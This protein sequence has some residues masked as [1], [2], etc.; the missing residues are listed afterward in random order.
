MARVSFSV[1]IFLALFDSSSQQA[2]P[3]QV[4][5]SKMNYGPDG[6]WHA[7]TVELGSPGQAI[8]LLP[9]GTFRS[10]IVTNYACCG[11]ANMFYPDQSSSLKEG[12]M[13]ILLGRISYDGSTPIGSGWT[14]G[15]L[16]YASTNA[17]AVTDTLVLSNGPS[18]SNATV[19]D[20]D[21]Y[22]WSNVQVVR[23][24]GFLYPLQI[25]QLALGNAG[26]NQT[27]TRPG[28]PSIN[29]SLVPNDL[30]DQ[31][32][33]DSS[34]F[35]LHYGSAPLGLDLSLWFGGY[36]QLR[37]LAPVSAQEYADAGSFFIDLYDIGIGVAEGRSP[38]TNAPSQG[39]LAS[40]NDTLSHNGSIQVL[41]NPVAPYLNLPKST[42]DAIAKNLPV[43]YNTKY[44]FYL[45]NTNDPQ[46]IN[47]VTSPA[48]LNFSFAL[49]GGLS[50][51]A[52]K[53]P[54]QLLNLTL[55]S[56]LTPEP[57]QYFPC[58][59]PRDPNTQ[60]YSLGRA[61]LQAAF[62]G[63]NWDEG[64]HWYLAQAPGP[65]VASNPD[66]QP[67]QGLSGFEPSPGDSDSWANTWNK[68]WKVTPDEASP[69]P[70]PPPAPSKG[71][72]S[73]GAIAGIAT[74][75]VSGVAAVLAT[76]WLLYRRRQQATKA[77]ATA[78][79]HK[80]GQ[81]QP[82]VDQPPELPN[83]GYAP[84]ELGHEGAALGPSELSGRER[85]EMEHQSE[86]VGSRAGA[87]S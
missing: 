36:D 16:M 86:L 34:S 80:V 69:T 72:I 22:M 14:N 51:F 82:F 68:T 73:G 5:Q 32:I 13:D 50:N 29:A 58:Q 42:C 85:Y 30:K 66:Y 75:A 55:E 84:S 62:L 53:V 52:I 6:P 33:I 12:D 49:N 77:E 74:G 81:S 2:Y 61:F 3:L 35:G 79:V 21:I 43:T 26:S 48:Y 65:G 20:F 47:I 38:F 40:G 8:D 64:H 76:A 46:Y 67:I 87:A 28:S 1:I 41:I 19:N 78:Y 39:L 11:S 44:G 57:I 17:S 63:V 31:N 71:G 60:I 54:F 10:Q 70:I 83:S 7:V 24:D 18:T 56:P 37:A 9:G 25:G 59:P 4:R 15:A 45:W 27:F 23:S